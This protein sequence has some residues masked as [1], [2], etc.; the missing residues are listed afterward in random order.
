MSLISII[1][2]LLL[3]Q[4]RPLTTSRVDAVLARWA[5]FLDGHLNA[6]EQRHGLVAWLLGVALPALLV[7]AVG[8]AV[9]WSNRLLGIGY[10]IVILY[11]TVGF[12]Q[13]SH[14][15][16]DIHLALRM[17]ELD[18]AR[19]LLGE[20]RGESAERLGSGEV[21]RL[22]IEQALLSSHRHVFAPLFW[23]V[24]L[25]PGGAVAYR[26]ALFLSREW[27]GRGDLEFGDF[28][29]FSRQAFALVDWVPVRA[30][31][32]AFAIVGDFEGAI[33]CWRSQAAR[34][35]DPSAGVLL[36]SGAGALGVRL[37]GPTMG[38][39]VLGDPAVRPDLGTD[40]EADADFMQSTIGLVW[41]TLVMS[42]MLLALIIVAGWVGG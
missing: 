37:G 18:R 30:T 24:L 5:R 29:L 33:Y 7:L 21:A 1:V 6:G 23:F 16:T 17:G 27:G 26:L 3:E 8:L 10:D 39:G 38:D 36:A 31:A 14:Y 34:W 35:P 40:D 15:Y 19:Q 32:A 41:R 9:A 28:G 20:W 2:A 4:A 12:R 22:A 25:G 13:F 11:V 42:L